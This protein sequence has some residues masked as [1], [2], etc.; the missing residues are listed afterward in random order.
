MSAHSGARLSV[1]AQPRGLQ[2]SSFLPRPRPCSEH[3][4]GAGWTRPP[5][6]CLWRVLDHT[7]L[8]FSLL[9]AEGTIKVNGDMSVKV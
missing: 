5:P 1:G 3:G 9:T 4:V 8:Y 6:L 7:A 2:G